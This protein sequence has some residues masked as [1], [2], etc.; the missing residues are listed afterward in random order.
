MQRHPVA[1]PPY[2]RIVVALDG[3]D[4][5]AAAIPTAAALAKASDAEL[6][7]FSAVNPGSEREI[8]RIIDRQLL[9]A[10]VTADQR[11]V[12]TTSRSASSWIAEMMHREQ[13]SE[14]NTL[15]VCT[16]PGHA[17]T[18]ELRGSFAENV[19]QLTGG[20]VLIVG[21]GCQR[22]TAATPGAGR[23]IVGADDAHL[24]DRIAHLATGWSHAYGLDVDLVHV[25][26]GSTA[27]RIVEHATWR[28][29]RERLRH[30]TRTAQAMH[31]DSGRLA[32]LVIEEGR[33]P[34]DAIVRRAADPAIAAVIVASHRR[35]SIARLLFGSVAMRVV[36]E[37]PCPVLVVRPENASDAEAAG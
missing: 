17:R 7:T 18:G 11:I 23:L 32:K 36:R 13:T 21:Q 19:L 10:D 3:S 8:T 20:P 6:V 5:G 29:T 2:T 4:R 22:T 16:D 28:S 34:A 33:D 1:A 24:N 30:H 27:D 9:E 25:R 37:S 31:D 12:E 14:D 15:V 26:T 35:P